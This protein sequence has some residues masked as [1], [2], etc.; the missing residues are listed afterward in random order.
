[1]NRGLVIV[2]VILVVVGVAYASGITG[3]GI[4]DFFKGGGRPSTQVAPPL[5]D[6]AGAQDEYSG[7]VASQI[8]KD[9]PQNKLGVLGVKDRSMVNRLMGELRE[10]VGKDE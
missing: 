5:V 7:V 9:A 10:A 1:M 8:F 2:I 4:L 3:N 6:V